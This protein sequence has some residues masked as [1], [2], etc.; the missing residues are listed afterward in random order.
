MKVTFVGTGDAF[1]SGGRFNTCFHL[2]TATATVLVDCGASS[3]VAMNRLNIDPNPI[4]AIILSH[5]HGDH[6]GGLPFFLLECQFVTRRTEPLTIVGP[7]GMEVR[8]RALCEAMFPGSSTANRRFAVHYVEIA[9]GSRPRDICGIGVESRE[10]I[11]PSG[12]P[13]TALRLECGG[14]VFAYSG[15]TEWTDALYAIARD[16]DLFVCECY[17]HDQD[18]PYHLSYKTLLARRDRFGARRMML[19]HMGRDVLAKR[20]EITFE[21]AED[22]G[23]V[24]L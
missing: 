11:H 15:D 2:E 8:V 22:G 6:F 3:L 23:V 14:K 17:A 7:P 13:A 24:T 9:P 10:V 16:A 18:V 4:G 19:T 21:M 5:L 12:A 1:G 20:N